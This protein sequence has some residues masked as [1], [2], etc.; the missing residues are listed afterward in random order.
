MNDKIVECL[1]DYENHGQTLRAYRDEYIEK[2]EQ[3]KAESAQL[4]LVLS[5]YQ[6]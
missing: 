3:F 4:K 5:Q 2:C 1:A 6:D